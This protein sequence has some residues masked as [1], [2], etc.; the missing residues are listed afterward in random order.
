[1]N[2]LLLVDKPAGVTS[3]D[4]VRVVKRRWRV[5]TGHLGT[6]DP[7]ASGLLPICVGEGTKIAQF[8]NGADKAY[9]GEIRLGTRTDTGDPTGTVVET[10]PAYPIAVQDLERVRRRFVGEL[11]QTPPMYSALKRRGTPLYALA[12]RGIEVERAPRCVHIHDLA[13]ILT[14]PTVLAFSVSCS[15][16][17]YVRVLAEDLAAALGTV[18]H[19]QSLRRT[20]FGP[21]RVEEAVRLECWPAEGPTLVGL[22]DALDGLREFRVNAGVADLLRRGQGPPLDELDGGSPGETAKVV[23]AAGALVAV[24][25]TGTTGRWRFARVFAPPDRSD[26]PHG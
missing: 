19:L 3:A 10:A 6:L 14:E 11:R 12:R 7:F 5:K 1:M 15:K 21:F 18:G 20:R 13:L 25:V 8:L 4:V 9:V 24:I 17:T 2:G 22:R 16:G 26:M 23:D